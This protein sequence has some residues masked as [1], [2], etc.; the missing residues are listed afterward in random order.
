MTA[1]DEARTLLRQYDLADA[2][3]TSAAGVANDVFLTPSVVIRLNEGR[4]RDAF[5]HEAH[6]LNSLPATVPH[7]AAL[8]HGKRQ[9]AGEYII[10]ERVPGRTLDQVWPTLSPESRRRVTLDLARITQ[11]LHSIPLTPGM[12]NPW[13]TDALTVPIYADAYHA[14][15][16]HYLPLIASAQSV[17]P[18][19]ATVLADI[20]GFIEDRLGA[21]ADEVAPV[22]VHADLHFRNVLAID[23]RVTG[24]ID[25]EGCRPAAPD[26]ELDMIIRFFGAEQQFGSTEVNDYSGVIGW[27]R[28]GYPGLFAHPRLVERIEVYEALWHLVQLHHWRPE[29]VSFRDPSDAFHDLLDG[30]FSSRVTTLLAP[31]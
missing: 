20:Q 13:F 15:I 24:V 4:F 31:R 19:T 9:N 12:D 2:E 28:E 3:L 17:C 1:A 25:F 6:M 26:V 11:A 16:S 21:F 10:L 22:L 14:P 8:A 18:D 29:Y 23:D 30:V 7:P 27:L 5:A